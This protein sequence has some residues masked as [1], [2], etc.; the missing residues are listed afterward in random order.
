M[1]ASIRQNIQSQG[2]SLAQDVVKVNFFGGADKMSPFRCF[3]SICHQRSAVCVGI[4][5]EGLVE[6][7]GKCR[8]EGVLVWSMFPGRAFSKKSRVFR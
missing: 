5:L 1:S 6:L 8:G 4:C 7:Y 3:G 2:L